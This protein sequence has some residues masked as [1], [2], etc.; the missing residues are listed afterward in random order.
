[1]N[2][3]QVVAE[4]FR[5]LG[6]NQQQDVLAFIEL[7]QNQ[8]ITPPAPDELGK[9]DT[10]IAR[11]IARAQAIAPQPPELIWQRFDAIRQR[12]ANL[13]ASQ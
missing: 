1:M 6:P 10:I 11:G 9:V 13:R 2:I 4:K 7:L 8:V 12:L 3:E 5:V